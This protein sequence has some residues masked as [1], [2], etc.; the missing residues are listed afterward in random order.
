[1]VMLSDIVMEVV[2][3]VVRDIAVEGEQSRR[4][5]AKLSD[6]QSKEAIVRLTYDH[7]KKKWKGVHRRNCRILPEEA[8]RNLCDAV[9]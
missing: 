3:D 2:P 5:A 7:C 8:V 1:M 6:P 9:C 4:L